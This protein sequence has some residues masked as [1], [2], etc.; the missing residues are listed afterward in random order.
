MDGSYLMHFDTP[1]EWY[2]TVSFVSLRCSQTKW[3]VE[4]DAYNGRFEALP[5]CQ[6][7]PDFQWYQQLSIFLDKV[8]L[9]ILDNSLVNNPGPRSVDHCLCKTDQCPTPLSHGP[10]LL[11]QFAT[12]LWFLKQGAGDIIALSAAVETRTFDGLVKSLG[13]GFIETIKVHAGP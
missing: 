1:Q 7:T 6:H 3:E 10:G 13:S 2:A 12:Q 4:F 9:L 5:I 11:D 8:K